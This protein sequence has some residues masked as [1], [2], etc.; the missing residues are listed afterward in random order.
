MLQNMLALLSQLC[1]KSGPRT[2]NREGKRVKGKRTGC[3][4]KTSK[5]KDRKFKAV[6]LENRKC[7]TKQMN[8]WAE[9]E[10]NVCRKWDLQTE[11]QNKNYHWHL[12]RTKKKRM[13]ENKVPVG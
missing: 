13:K 2:N 11:K 1:L 3:P 7:T 9:T 4:S 10:V 6:C 12:N 5:H 8:N